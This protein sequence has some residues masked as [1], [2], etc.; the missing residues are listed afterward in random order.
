MHPKYEQA[1]E[2]TKEVIDAACEV[3][4]H[5]N[6]GLL[7]SIYQKCLAHELKLRGHTVKTEA[8]AVIRYA[9]F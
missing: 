6:I 8:P 5:F 1:N 3:R 4:E 2:L 9:D 7:E